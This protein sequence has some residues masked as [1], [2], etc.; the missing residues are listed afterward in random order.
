MK[1]IQLS[2]HGLD[3]FAVVDLDDPVP[4][5]GEVLLR[6]TAASVNYRDLAVASGR[7]GNRLPLIP[8][9]DG[10]GVVE[11]IGAGVTRVAIGDRVSPIY[12]PRWLS[13]PLVEG[14]AALGGELDGV[15]RQKMVVDAEA[16]VRVPDHLSDAEAA[17]LTVAGV[18]AWSALVD[19]G[20]VKPGDVVLVEGTGGVAL[21][22]LQFAKLAGARVAII[23]SSN[24]KLGRARELGADFAVNYRET[25]DWGADVARLTGGVNLVVETVG[26]ETLSQ[27]VAAT[28]RDA[29]IAQVGFL[30]GVGAALPLQLLVP[31]GVELRGI[32]VGGRDRY[33]QM[34]R[35][36]SAHGLRPVVGTTLAFDQLPVALGMIAKGGHFGKIVI[37]IT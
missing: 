5:V 7:H 18:T 12:A 28:A 4:G 30:S 32:L 26:A 24:E 17:T 9:S 11:A 13:G 21:F 36:I 34:N 2:A 8:L 14:M 6:M 27:A 25:P 37:E 16:V 20:R 33:Q 22:A 19:F 3:A 10:V 1:A 29:R 23:S 31:R 15:L 35:A